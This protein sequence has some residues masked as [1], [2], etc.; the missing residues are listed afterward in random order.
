[1]SFMRSGSVHPSHSI[2]DTPHTVSWDYHINMPFWKRMWNQG[3]DE[4]CSLTAGCKR[5][6]WQG[7]VPI[8]QI[9]GSTTSW[10]GK[11]QTWGCHASCRD[12]NTCSTV[13]WGC[14]I[15]WL[16]HTPRCKVHR[17]DTDQDFV[18]GARTALPQR[19]WGSR[20]SCPYRLIR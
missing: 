6:R 17:W 15:A 12:M 19:P 10:K 11:Q 9:C 16:H 4:C 1:M 2:T 14:R 13:I 8:C 18:V 20:P 7:T 5:Q 3:H